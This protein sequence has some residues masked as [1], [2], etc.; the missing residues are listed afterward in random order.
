MLFD[1]K[2]LHNNYLTHLDSVKVLTLSSFVSSLQVYNLSRN[3]RAD[4]LH[5]LNLACTY[6]MLLSEFK[7]FGDLKILIRDCINV[8]NEDFDGEEVGAS[9]FDTW[10]DSSRNIDFKSIR[11]NIKRCYDNINCV[12]M[13][14][15]GIIVSTIRLSDARINEINERFKDQI[16]KF[17][18]RII[19]PSNLKAKKIDGNI[20][21]C[22]Q[23]LR[24]FQIRFNELNSNSDLNLYSFEV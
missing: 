10:F 8:T 21:N 6:G 13:P 1:C 14:N 11:N 15:P 23:F 9:Y 17:V 18:L 16:Q 19:S 12:L 3:I 24:H 2:G 7:P 5:F 4:D 22:S 20:V